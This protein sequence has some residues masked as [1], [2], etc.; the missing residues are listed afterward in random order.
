MFGLMLRY[1]WMDCKVFH[2]TCVI[3]SE[4]VPCLSTRF[5]LY[6]LVCI[7]PWA[8]GYRCLCID[9]YVSAPTSRLGPLGMAQGPLGMAQGPL[10]MAHGPLGMAHSPLGM[11][12]GPLGIAQ[13]PLGMCPGSPGYVSRVPWVWPRVPWV[14]PRVPWV[15]VQGPLGMC[16]GSPGY[17]PWSPGYVPRVPWVCVQPGWRWSYTLSY[18][19]AVSVVSSN[20]RYCG[21]RCS[22]CALQV[23]IISE[24]YR[25]VSSGREALA[26]LTGLC[27]RCPAQ[28]G[29]LESKLSHSSIGSPLAKKVSLVQCEVE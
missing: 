21:V 29:W 9:P 24:E 25:F 27:T 6:C 2:Q 10:G 20:F 18:Q 3:A 4:F 22:F 28:R 19:F 5:R 23:D 11:A 26:V 16:P 8:Y 12:Q 14:W 7:R 17:G 13:G 1:V 15:C